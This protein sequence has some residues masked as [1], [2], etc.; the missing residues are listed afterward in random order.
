MGG[1]NVL[2][3]LWPSRCGL[4]RSKTCCAWSCSPRPPR[5]R[6][7]VCPVQMQRYGNVLL[8]QLTTRLQGLLR[9]SD[10]VARLGGDEFGLLLPATNAMGATSAADKLLMALDQPFGLEAHSF[11]V[12]AS[13]GIAVYPQ[14]GEDVTTLL[15]R[16]DIAMYA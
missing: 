1:P 13:I 16:A 15:R 11:M 12:E 9:E 6:R 5:R 7:L 3:L 8:Q 10:T 14:H 4:T 2:S